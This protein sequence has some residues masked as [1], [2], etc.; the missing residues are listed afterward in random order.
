MFYKMKYNINEKINIGNLYKCLISQFFDQVSSK[1]MVAPSK[2]Q[3]FKWKLLMGV[4]RFFK[5]D[6][7]VQKY[8]SVTKN[9]GGHFI[10]INPQIF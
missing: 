2:Y 7:Q 4:G 8:F 9:V 3:N 5:V 1:L 6:R 10:K